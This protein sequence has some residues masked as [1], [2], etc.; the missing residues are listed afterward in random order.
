MSEEKQAD[1]PATDK[2]KRKI[3]IIGTAPS[4]VKLAPYDDPTWEIW[5]LKVWNIQRW[6]VFFEVHE[7]TEGVKRWPKE[8]SQWLTKEHKDEKGN[9]KPLFTQGKVLE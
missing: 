4:S 6:D 2:P 1:A 5:A 9:L 8:Y 3:A 7:A